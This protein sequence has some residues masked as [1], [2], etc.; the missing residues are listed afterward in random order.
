MKTFI[1]FQCNKAIR[2]NQNGI[3]CNNINHWLKDKYTSLTNDQFKL[4][5]K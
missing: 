3:N 1:C 4:F 5:C 2:K